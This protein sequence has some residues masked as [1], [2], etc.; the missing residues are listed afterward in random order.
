MQLHSVVVTGAGGFIGTALTRRLLS[1]GVS[2]TCVRRH[3]PTTND[4]IPRGAR[5]VAVDDLT[6]LADPTHA[7]ALVSGRV[8]AV[9]HLAAYGVRPNDRD[10]ATL[11]SVNVDAPAALVA[12]AHAWNAPVIVGAGS[13]A[14]YAP[15][16]AGVPMREDHPLMIPAPAIPAASAD[17]SGASQPP[18]GAPAPEASG[19]GSSKALGGLRFLARARAYGIRALWLRLFGVYGP[20]EG[21]ERLGPYLLRTL[22][23]GEPALLTPG[24]QQRDQVFIDDVVNALL[25]GAAGGAP[26]GAFNV[27]TGRPSSVRHIAEALAQAAGAPPHL[28]RFGERPY[29]PDEQMWMVGDP[30]AFRG[31]TGWTARVGL[32]DGAARLAAWWREFATPASAGTPS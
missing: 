16:N 30:A 24:E 31:A 13:C 26:T 22:A 7:R 10:P 32:N 19:Y 9:F 4:S 6:A 23:R 1:A 12:A 28:L 5:V 29:R 27:C 14:E 2:V 18:P 15:G 17:V 21:P 3:A 8:D 20:G 25:V 11:R